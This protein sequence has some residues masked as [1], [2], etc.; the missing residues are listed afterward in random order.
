MIGSRTEP[1]QT[2]WPDRPTEGGTAR[3]AT[4]REQGEGHGCRNATDERARDCAREWWPSAVGCVSSISTGTVDWSGP[5]GPRDSGQRSKKIERQ[6]RGTTCRSGWES[7]APPSTQASGGR[8]FKASPLHSQQVVRSPL[9]GPQV[10][11][12][13][14]TIVFPVIMCY[15]GQQ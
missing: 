5:A 4:H 13:G 6:R 10:V 15:V 8:P 3:L 9:G 1:K 7:I 14:Q 2:T 12:P 11:V